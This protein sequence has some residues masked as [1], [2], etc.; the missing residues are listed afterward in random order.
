MEE[1]WKDIKE[2]EGMYQ[3]SNLGR[4]KSLKYGKEYIKKISIHHSNYNIIKLHKDGVGKTFQIH[5][6]VAQHFIPNPDNLP[7]VNHKDENT[8]NNSVN[9]LEWCD[10]KYNANYGTAIQRR[11]NTISKPV[12]QYTL[13][14]EFVR[15]WSSVKE[16]KA[17]GYFCDAVCRGVRKTHKGFIWKYKRK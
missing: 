6:L 2:Y 16:C 17:Q 3:I 8:L 11:S 7:Q 12:L 1:I 4:V 9:N 14:G 10:S 5:R 15:E 13:D